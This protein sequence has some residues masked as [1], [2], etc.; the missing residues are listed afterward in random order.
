MEAQERGVPTVF[1]IP[2]IQFFVGGLLFIA[3][4]Y[5]QRDLVILTL[6][7]LGMVIGVRLWTPDQPFRFNMPFSGR[8]TETLSRRKTHVT[9]S[10]AENKKFLPIWLEII[11]PVRG[12]IH[13]PTPKRHVNRRAACCGTRGPGSCGS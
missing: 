9:A 5:G 13:L 10:S 8:Q 2:L 12:L 4:L 3:L 11:I 7:V 6:L 1:V